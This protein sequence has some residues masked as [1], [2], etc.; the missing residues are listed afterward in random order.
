ML[1]LLSLLI[2]VVLLLQRVS[3]YNLHFLI[4]HSLYCTPASLGASCSS[5][6]CSNSSLMLGNV[7]AQPTSGGCGVSSC[8]Y[9]GLVNGSIVTS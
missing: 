6:Q 5:M 7:T 3:D 2:S 1:P 9:G 4:S 8:S